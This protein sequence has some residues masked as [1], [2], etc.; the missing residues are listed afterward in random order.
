MLRF[1]KPNQKIM[2]MALA[3]T[4]IIIKDNSAVMFVFAD[5]NCSLA[6]K[7]NDS[8]FHYFNSEDERKIL[9]KC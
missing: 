5:I 6:L 7:S 4:I 9:Q 3:K 2:Q 8:K 1:L